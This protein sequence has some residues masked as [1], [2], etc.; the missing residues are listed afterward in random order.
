MNIN[1]YSVDLEVAG[2][3]MISPK[4]VV[5]VVGQKKPVP[6]FKNSH[7]NLPF[8]SHDSGSN[9]TSF[10]NSRG[11]IPNLLTREKGILRQNTS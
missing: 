1:D 11:M 3:Q 9:F 7:D 8:F 5:K 6:I 10:E 2:S 4:A